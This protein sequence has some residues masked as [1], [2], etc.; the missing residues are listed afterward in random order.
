MRE[1]R[2]IIWDRQWQ[3]F[4]KFTLVVAQ[5][6]QIEINSLFIYKTLGDVAIE[7]CTFLVD[8]S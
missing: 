7:T 8:K 5:L 1:N 2:D 3:V 4:F 6:F